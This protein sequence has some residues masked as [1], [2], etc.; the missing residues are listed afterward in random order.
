MIPGITGATGFVGMVHVAAL[1]RAGIRPRVLVRDG[2]PW[3][4]NPP[5]EVEVVVGDLHNHEALKSFTAGLSHI[6][7]YAARASFKAPEEQLIAINVEGTQNLLQATASETRIVMASTQAVVLRDN[8]IVD[9]DES[10]STN[11]VDF[12][13]YGRSKARAEALVT[14]HENGFV[15][16][17]P[18]VWGAG[19]TN[20]LPT[21]LKPKLRGYMRFIDHGRNRI[22]T[23]HAANLVA[24]MH[25]VGI[26]ES[27]AERIFFATDA[28]PIGVKTFTNDLLVACGLEAESR[29]SPSWMVRGYSLL[30]KARGKSPVIPRAS[31]I[32]MT[33]DQIFSD[34]RLRER[35]GHQD[36]VSRR[37]GM[38]EL[39]HWCQAMGGATR[40]VEGRRQGKN[41]ELVEAIWAFLLEESTSTRALSECLTS[42]R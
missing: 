35:T 36:L 19:D 24:A 11:A 23:V 4:G 31:L 20:N 25:R 13:P 29:S 8:D 12:D 6:F 38:D 32:Y 5:G 2:H 41:Q 42:E 3:A 16:R 10:L 26:S 34:A 22:E 7:H 14:Q 30:R 1:C 37:Q 33:R 15:V 40:L 17:P 18:W 28:E 27:M 39:T 9:G 21:V